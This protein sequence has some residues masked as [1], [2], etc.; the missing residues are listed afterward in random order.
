LFFYK[1]CKELDYATDEVL[2]CIPLPRNKQL[3]FRT[4]RPSLEVQMQIEARW[5]TPK[6]PESKLQKIIVG[7]QLRRGQADATVFSDVVVNADYSDSVGHIVGNCCFCWA[8]RK[9]IWRGVGE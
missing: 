2:A 5:V 3:L 9:T 4:R 1:V 8:P 7:T 6:S